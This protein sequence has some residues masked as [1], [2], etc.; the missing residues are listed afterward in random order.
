M[1]EKTGNEDIKPM[2][3]EGVI[4]SNHREELV[5]RLPYSTEE[6][7]QDVTLRKDI[8]PYPD[9]GYTSLIGRKIRITINVEVL[10]E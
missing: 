7:P 2:I 4:I 8:L 10:D 1:E 3:I 6:N 9:E 5:L